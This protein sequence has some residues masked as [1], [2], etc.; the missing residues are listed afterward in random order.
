M[1]YWEIFLAGY[2]G[3][4]LAQG[5]AHGHTNTAHTQL[6][7]LLRESLLGTMVGTRRRENNHI[8]GTPKRREQ[9]R[10]ET[11]RS[12]STDETIPKQKTLNA[13]T[14]GGGVEC[15]N[16]ILDTPYPPS[17]KT[18]RETSISAP[19]TRPKNKIIKT[20][21][22]LPQ[23]TRPSQPCHPS[24]MQTSTATTERCGPARRPTTRA[25]R[26]STSPTSPA[27]GS[28][29]PCCC[30]PWRWSRRTTSTAPCASRGTWCCSC[31][32]RGR[33]ASWARRRWSPCAFGS[34]RGGLWRRLGGGGLAGGLVG[35]VG[36]GACGRGGLG[37]KVWDRGRG[38]M[39][40]RRTPF[41]AVASV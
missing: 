6:F 3:N 13:M 1:R 18:N 34:G 4:V 15:T 16:C 35:W 12:S 38:E 7:P 14:S 29:T 39:G 20:P 9:E 28:P 26:P 37:G 23:T 5:I 25:R 19:Q 40:E 36:V 27:G 32:R 17:P 31:C 8:F 30:C 33:R 22:V 21:P 24:P 2:D 11:N 10:R 41:D